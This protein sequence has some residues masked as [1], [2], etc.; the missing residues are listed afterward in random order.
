[1][2]RLTLLACA[3]A[4]GAAALATPL[5]SQEILVSPAEDGIAHFVRTVSHQLDRN[6]A[7]VSLPLRAA[8]QGTVR[9]RFEIDQAGRAA[10][11]SYYSRSGDRAADRAAMQAVAR[12]GA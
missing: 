9:L 1:M 7:R 10:N 3:A 2:N 5:A 8:P 6:L 11:I 4:V 12:L